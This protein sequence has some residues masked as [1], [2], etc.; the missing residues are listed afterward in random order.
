MKAITICQPY[1]WLITLPTT[2]PRHKR[3][4]NRTW[5]TSYRG[6]ILIHAGKSRA[7]LDSWDDITP[8]ESSRLVFG[9]LVAR[10]RLV[11]CLSLAQVRRQPQG[12]PLAWVRAHQHAEGPYC[13]IIEDVEPMAPVYC[14]GQQ[15]LWDWTEPAPIAGGLF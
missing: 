1:A 9:A 4:E 12:S 2:D 6:P 7:W 11:D 13:W 5:F 10:A 14:A 15:G 8:A 3:I